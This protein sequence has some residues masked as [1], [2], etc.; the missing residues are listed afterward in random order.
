M[1]HAQQL[2]SIN[3]AS[4]LFADAFLTEASYLKFLSV[5]GRDTEMQAFLARLQLGRQEGGLSA[6]WINADPPKYVQIAD[7]ASIEKLS[8]RMP[9]DNLFGEVTHLWLFDGTGVTPDYVGRRA[10]FFFSPEEAAQG[11]QEAW[12]ER[13]WTRVREL[14]HLPLLP[15][16]RDVVLDGFNERGFLRRLD[17]VGIAAVQISLPEGEI[18][19]TLTDWIASGRLTV[20]QNRQEVS[21][22]GAK[23]GCHV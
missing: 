18:E 2:M 3:E 17:G 4:G 9:K 14:C 6:F 7:I 22:D 21:N 20:P 19:Q 16:W 23:G 15:I 5:W 1:K 13:L 8:G 11:G 10:L 12:R